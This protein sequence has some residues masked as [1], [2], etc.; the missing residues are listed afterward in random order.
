MQKE[1]FPHRIGIVRSERMPAEL[2]ELGGASGD[3]A[4]PQGHVMQALAALAK[5]V[6]EKALRADRLDQLD[7]P[8]SRELKLRPAESLRGFGR[9]H[10]E[11]SPKDVADQRHHGRNSFSRDRH[12][13]EPVRNRRPAL[14]DRHAGRS[15][16]ISMMSIAC[17]WLGIVMFEVAQSM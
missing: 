14:S 8:A 10:Q 3:I 2:F 13:V 17:Q 11:A 1:L 7:H 16:T 12:V 9:A 15:I 6:M 4:D 5:K